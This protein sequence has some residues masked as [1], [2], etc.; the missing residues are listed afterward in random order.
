MVE[1]VFVENVYFSGLAFCNVTGRCICN[2]CKCMSLGCFYF[3]WNLGYDTLE[4]KCMLHALNGSSMLHDR[5]KENKD[6][7][8]QWPTEPGQVT[9]A[10]FVCCEKKVRAR[11]SENLWVFNL[12]VFASLFIGIAA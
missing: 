1:M 9:F 4:M 12:R 5:I 7:T 11:S 8:A 6:N 2:M 3:S 10:C